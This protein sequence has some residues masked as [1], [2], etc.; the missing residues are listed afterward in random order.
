MAPWARIK[1]RDLGIEIDMDLAQLGG[2]T[3]FLVCREN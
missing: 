1:G 2:G 3:K